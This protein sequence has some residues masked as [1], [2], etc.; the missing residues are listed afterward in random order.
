MLGQPSADTCRWRQRQATTNALAVSPP[1]QAVSCWA[2][3][4]QDCCAGRVSSFTV[5]L[6]PR[7]T[8]ESTRAGGAMLLRSWSIGRARSQTIHKDAKHFQTMF[9]MLSKQRTILLPQPPEPVLSHLTDRLL[10]CCGPVMCSL[11]LSR[12]ACWGPVAMEAEEEKKE[13]AKTIVA[14]SYAH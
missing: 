3:H 11:S 6:A 13:I 9:V 8:K 12:N 2:P 5:D 14:E 1:G 7:R 4:V 10:S